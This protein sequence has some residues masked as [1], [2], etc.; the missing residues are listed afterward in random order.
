MSLLWPSPVRV[1]NK[2]LLVHALLFGGGHGY[3]CLQ[4]YIHACQT[5]KAWGM[6]PRLLRTY[7]RYL[8]FAMLC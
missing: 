1:R 7:V 2:F 5:K 4:T 3:P 8:V 6:N